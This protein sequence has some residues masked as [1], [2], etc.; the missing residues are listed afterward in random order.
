LAAP[1]WRRHQRRFT[2]EEQCQQQHEQRP[3][4]SIVSAPIAVFF[5]VAEAKLVTFDAFTHKKPFFR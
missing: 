1:V 5:F 4:A 3:T 2:N